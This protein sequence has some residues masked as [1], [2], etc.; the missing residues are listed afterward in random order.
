MHHIERW[1]RRVEAASGSNETPA[2]FATR[3]D[4][5]TRCQLMENVSTVQKLQSP[6]RARCSS[7]IAAMTFRR[8]REMPLCG[9]F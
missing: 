6:P 2:A 4:G 8:T 7:S 3:T 9:M 5:D 1:L